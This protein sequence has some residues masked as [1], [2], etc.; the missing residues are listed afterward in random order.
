MERVKNFP[1]GVKQLCYDI[2]RYN[3]IHDA[4]RTPL[5]AWT[6][7]N[8]PLV[9]QKDDH[10]FVIVDQELRPGR[11]P[12]REHEEQ[13]RLKDDI[14]K[15][16]PIIA[17]WI[18]PIIG[19]LPMILVI[20]CPRQALSRQFYTPYEKELYASIEYRQC[21]NHFMDVAQHCFSS[22]MMNPDKLEIVAQGRD[23]AGP[24]L[25]LMPFYE[26]FT[27]AKLVDTRLQTGRLSHLDMYPREYLVS[28]ALANGLYQ[29]YPE[30]LCVWAARLVPWLRREVRRIANNVATDDR[31]L[32]EEAYDSNGC[33]SMTNQEAQDACLMRGLP[34]TVSYAEMRKCLTNHLVMIK[35]L[36]KR[37]P[38]DRPTEALM[39]FTIHL[40]AI[41]Y[42]LQQKGV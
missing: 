42:Y 38:D 17:L 32:L 23:A 4:S 21:R 22:L 29:S 13:R 33:E 5:N 7:R 12:R 36:K 40:S 20:C 10:R 8:E 30:P 31:L 14:R 9:N 37:L 39:L 11:I 41:R 26:V 27:D 18:P 25:D 15:V 3:N 35:K 2:L 16:G 28:L 34:V 1:L 19:Y 24:V 6:I